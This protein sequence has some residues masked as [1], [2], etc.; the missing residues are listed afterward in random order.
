MQH[1]A[2]RITA[3][4]TAV[5]TCT[6]TLYRSDRQKRSVPHVRPSQ[7]P[8]RARL[9]ASSP[10][11]K[12]RSAVTPDGMAGCFWKRDRPSQ[13]ADTSWVVG[14]WRT[15]YPRPC[16]SDLPTGWSGET[17]KSGWGSA[18]M[19]LTQWN[20]GYLVRAA[21]GHHMLQRHWTQPA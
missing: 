19:G 10:S 20:N 18:G 17:G 14:G 8:Q 7:N 21:A 12:T 3:S 1:P 13:R 16:M 5:S 6:L 4:N 11:A 15:L 2:S 9:K